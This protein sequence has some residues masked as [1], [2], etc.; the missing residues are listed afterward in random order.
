M[1]SRLTIIDRYLRGN[2]KQSARLEIR[3]TKEDLEELK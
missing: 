2:G 1:K 3:I